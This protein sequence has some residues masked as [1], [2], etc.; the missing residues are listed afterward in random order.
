M[1]Q[2]TKAETSVLLLDYDGTLAPFQLDRLR[3]Y[4]YPGVVQLLNSIIKNGRSKVVIVSG[5]PVAE[6]RPLLLPL[7]NIELW[8]SHGLEHQSA[9]G[10][11]RL[12]SVVPEISAS[13][14]EAEAWL[15]ATGLDH[16][17]EIKPGGVAVHWRGM[18]ESRIDSVRAHVFCGMTF[19]RIWSSSRRVTVS[20][21]ARCRR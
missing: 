13:L 10:T 2:L 12:I 9:D 7:Q 8:G 18:P 16:R 6:L 14:Q 1:G 4:P 20:R 19:T 15:S 21:T 17:A 3:A 5:R 11:S